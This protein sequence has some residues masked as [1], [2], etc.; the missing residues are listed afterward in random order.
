MRAAHS[1]EQA[2]EK[3]G[4]AVLTLKRW[5]AEGLIRP[6]I[7]IPMGTRKLYKW[8]DRDISKARKVKATR[9]RGPKPKVRK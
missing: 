6:S 8:T 7:V 3:I 1:T 4:V 5:L 9:K 2:A